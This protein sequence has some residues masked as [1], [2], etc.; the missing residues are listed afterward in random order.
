MLFVAI[1]FGWFVAA[2]ASALGLGRM[3]IL[4]E[5]DLWDGSND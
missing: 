1:A 3:Y 2:V 5:G 4:S